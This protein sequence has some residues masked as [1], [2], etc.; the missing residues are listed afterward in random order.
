MDIQ[1]HVGIRNFQ[2]AMEVIRVLDQQL[3]K[4]TWEHQHPADLFT[5]KRENFIGFSIQFG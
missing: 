5:F 2:T 4:T 1:I 3:L